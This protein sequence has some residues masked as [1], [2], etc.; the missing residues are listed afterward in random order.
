M[1][2]AA[3]TKFTNLTFYLLSSKKE[4]PKKKKTRKKQT[5]T[6][7]TQQHQTK[8]KHNSPGVARTRSLI[9]PRF[10]NNK[11]TTF[12]MISKFVFALFAIM[13]NTL[14]IYKI[15]T[16]EQTQEDNTDCKVPY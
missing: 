5:A 3:K 15:N 11:N 14:R 4:F 10:S 7:T 2:E 9:S 6:T 13:M 12:K 1:I 16:A 8:Q